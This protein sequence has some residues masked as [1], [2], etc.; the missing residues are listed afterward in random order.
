MDTIP[1]PYT[2]GVFDTLKQKY[3]GHSWVAP[4]ETNRGCPFKCSFCDWGSATASR[5]YRFDE[6]R[7]GN[8]VEW[9]GNQRVGTVICCDANFGIVNRDEKI[10]EAIVNSRKS[11][12][13]PF[14]LIAYRK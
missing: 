13:F 6:E 8:E 1:S 7:I 10:A 14:A 3:S 5:V 12:G 4:W 11:K 9:F 2:K